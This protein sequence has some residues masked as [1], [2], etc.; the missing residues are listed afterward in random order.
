MFL[1]GVGFPLSLGFG[2]SI[3][4]SSSFRRVSGALSGMLGSLRKLLEWV[5]KLSGRMNIKQSRCLGGL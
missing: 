5:R 2:V 4:Y 3:L 1:R